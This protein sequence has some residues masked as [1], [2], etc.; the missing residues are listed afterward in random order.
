[1]TIGRVVAHGAGYSDV[2]SGSGSGPAMH[3]LYKKSDSEK[4]SESEK[5][6]DHSLVQGERSQKRSSPL[7]VHIHTNSSA[8]SPSFPSSFGIAIVSCLFDLTLPLLFFPSAPDH[9]ISHNSL[10]RCE[11]TLNHIEI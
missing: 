11:A 3:L 4:G 2:G 9:E 10:M 7:F 1:M 6:R 5:K 8:S